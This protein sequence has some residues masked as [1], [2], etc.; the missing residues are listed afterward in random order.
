[1]FE[2]KITSDQKSRE[3][4]HCGDWVADKATVR[5][6]HRPFWAQFAH[7]S[8]VTRNFSLICFAPSDCYRLDFRLDDLLNYSGFGRCW[9][10]TAFWVSLTGLVR[11]TGLFCFTWLIRLTWLVRLTLLIRL[12][13]YLWLTCCGR[14]WVG[15][16][17]G[18][19]GLQQPGL[20]SILF[21][22]NILSWN[23]I[24][25]RHFDGL[26]VD[27]K[28]ES[29]ILVF[30]FAL[31]VKLVTTSSCQDNSVVCSRNACL[32]RI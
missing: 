8:R 27:K 20:Y 32:C 17:C 26:A 5:W 7:G 31:E 2:F 13:C 23:N 18:W 16:T 24:L 11:F 25:F 30:G 19:R 3:K 15:F 14:W 28:I 1:M 21:L 29:N 12:A 9:A 6:A 4:S 22:H 10:R